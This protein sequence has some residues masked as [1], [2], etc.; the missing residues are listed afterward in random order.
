MK[1]NWGTAIAAAYITFALATTTFV[2]F[3]MSRSVDLVRADYY[4]E[5]LRQDEHLQAIDNA[6]RLGSAAAIIDRT[7]AD[8]H[9]VEIALP[10]SQRGTARGTI[11]LYRPSNAAAD[12]RI[13]LSIDPAGRQLVAI[14]AVARGL[15]IV[16]LAWTADG[17]EFYLERRITLP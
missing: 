9:S 1:W 6:Y 10:P 3:A 16:Q 7:G 12:R 17:R 4:A 8:T 11:T 15:W 14:P 13:N 2:T 5:S